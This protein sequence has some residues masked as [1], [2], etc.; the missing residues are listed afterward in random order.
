MPKITV[1]KYTIPIELDCSDH[2]SVNIYVDELHERIAKLEAAL[3]F[4][5]DENNWEDVRCD[6]PKLPN[7]VAYLINAP[8]DKG[9]K[10]R[11]ALNE[12]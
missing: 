11:E 8:Q 10:A 2:K 4:Y 6:N 7:Y 5:A 12:K 1:G 3:R 9:A